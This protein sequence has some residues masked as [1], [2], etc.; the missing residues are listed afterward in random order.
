ML[1]ANLIHITRQILFP[2]SAASQDMVPMEARCIP[3]SLYGFNI[4]NTIPGLQHDFCALWNEII[5]EARNIMYSPN[6]AGI[7]R[8][9]RLLYIRLHPGTTDALNIFDPSSYPLCYPD[10]HPGETIHA[11]NP[12]L[13]TPLLPINPAHASR[14]PLDSSSPGDATNS[15]QLAIPPVS[16]QD[17]IPATSQHIAGARAAP[18]HNE[19]IIITTRL[20]KIPGS[21]SSASLIPVT[22]SALTGDL[23]SPVDSS[24]SQ[25]DRPPHVLTPS[26][27]SPT[28]LHVYLHRQPFSQ[29]LVLL[30]T[31]H[32]PGCMTISETRTFLHRKVGIMI[33]RRI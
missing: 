13:A 3:R 26:F 25:F 31:L 10:H 7:V 17:I 18:L 19:S 11:P 15:Q 6:L 32:C 33:H 23:H 12:I 22:S 30:Q 1:P 28:T 16:Q 20:S 2:S 9:I 8:K 14:H 29:S 27:S 21:L 5:L 4:R 24:M